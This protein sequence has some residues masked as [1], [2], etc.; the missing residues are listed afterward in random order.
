MRRKA[1]KKILVVASSFLLL[2]SLE[3]VSGDGKIFQFFLRN[4]LFEKLIATY[5][6]L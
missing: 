2:I 3:S 5:R 6:K 4:M 1:H